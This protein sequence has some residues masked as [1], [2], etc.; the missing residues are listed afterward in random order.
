M[1]AGVRKSSETPVLVDEPV[2]RTESG[3]GVRN[4]VNGRFVP[5]SA[6]WNPRETERV[7]PKKSK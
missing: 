5:P 7:K 2:K 6:K 1:F 3:A 4:S